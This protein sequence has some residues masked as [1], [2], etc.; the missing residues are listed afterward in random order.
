[1]LR[2]SFKLGRIFGITFR[3]HVTFLL[4]VILVFAAGLSEGGLM[5]GVR[6]VI[7]LC[8]VFSCV[9][10][11]EIGHSL[12]ARRFG[13]QT[14]SIILLPIGGVATL[15]EVPERPLQE[16]AM[17]LVGPLINLA[18]AA[19]LYALVGRWTGVRPPDLYPGSVGDLLGGL[20]SVN[21]LLAIFNLIPAFPMDGGRVLRGLAA[22]KTSYVRATSL[23]VSVGQA[24]SLVF[25]FA[26]I[27]FNLWLAI[28]G[29][30]LYIGAEAEKQQVMLRAILHNVPVWRAMST[31]FQTLHP[32][33]PLS[34]ALDYARRGCQDDFP[35]V[36]I[37][38]LRGILTR[39]GIL[40][41]ISHRGLDVPVS[42]V[43]E[44]GFVSV[45]ADE[46]LEQVYRRLL[47]EKK[48]AVA[49]IQ[50][51]EV[52]GMIGLDGISRYFMF[53]SALRGGG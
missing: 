28:I 24:I 52:R 19:V 1:M 34:V 10:T 8:A 40:A 3:V 49:V 29:A 32:Q 14:K 36:D 43:M 12:I 7:F 46:T 23:A 9:L 20:I 27:F 22:L 5:R 16:I 39:G 2:W 31:S 4:F 45:S 37:G 38:G 18:I 42:E 35:V 15:E 53:Q 6:G 13:K 50:A 17:S 33:Q 11:H 30:F 25:I 51:G 21:V 47:A 26:G 44:T 48:N 41:A